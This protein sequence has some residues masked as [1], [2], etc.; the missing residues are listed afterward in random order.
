MI[1]KFWTH[2]PSPFQTHSTI[3]PHKICALKFVRKNQNYK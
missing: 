3:E 1:Q 2:N